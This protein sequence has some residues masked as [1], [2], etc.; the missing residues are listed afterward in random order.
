MVDFHSF[1]RYAPKQKP[2]EKKDRASQIMS[3]KQGG[4]FGMDYLSEH[5]AFLIRQAE[6][7]S[8]EERFSDATGIYEMLLKTYPKSR[9]LLFNLARSYDYEDRVGKAIEVWE[10]L[11]KLEPDNVEYSYELALAYRDRGWRKKSIERFER[12]VMLDPGHAEAWE[13][14]IACHEE[15]DEWKQA[16][17]RTFQALEA[18]RDRKKGSVLLYVLAFEQFMEDDN[19]AEAEVCL[20]AILDVLM[21]SE[22]RH[23]GKY[24]MPIIRL[25]GHFSLTDSLA[26]FPYLRQI[27]DLSFDPDDSL[28]EKL[29]SLQARAEIIGIEDKGYSSLLT[30]LLEVIME[31]CDCQECENDIAAMEVSILSDIQGYAPHIVRLKH[32]HPIL[33]AKHSRFFNDVLSTLDLKKLLDQRLTKLSRQGLEPNIIKADD[34]LVEDNDDEYIKPVSQ[35]GT[36]RRDGPKVGRNDPCPCG[37]GMKYK[38]CCGA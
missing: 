25:I 34:R 16:R 32:E 31:D 22:Q 28:R 11:C 5:A 19:E 13:E 1:L 27:V 36:Y 6:I 24:L 15:A 26:F 30:G 3:Y 9:D 4:F 20:K 37:S 14:L 23:D 12:I 17:Q 18:V 35:G 8:Q 7:A 10:K 29:D 2:T 33:Y 38:K 21:N